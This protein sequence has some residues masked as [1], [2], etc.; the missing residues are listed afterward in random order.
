MTSESTHALE[1]RRPSLWV[2]T[3]SPSIW[4]AHFLL[5]YIGGAMFCGKFGGRAAG[6]G[7]LHAVII[8]LGLA[9]LAGIAMN[10]VAG[11][12]RHRHGGEEPPH[13]KDTAEDRSRFIGF[14]TVLLSGLSA[15][16]TVFVMIAVLLAGTC[17]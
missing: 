13:E 9:A 4:A 3:V 11:W 12:R 14:A 2:L 17:Y 10:G 7:T 6:L 8:G 5:S 16:A 15:M 1:E